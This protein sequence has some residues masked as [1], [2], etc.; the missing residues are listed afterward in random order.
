MTR[1]SKAIPR[2]VSEL[3]ALFFPPPH[4]LGKVKAHF[5]GD[6]LI[7]EVNSAAGEEAKDS[8][9]RRWGP[10]LIDNAERRM[11][12][13]LAAAGL[14]SE[15][16]I[17]T[18]VVFQTAHGEF[19]RGVRGL[20]KLAKHRGH[21]IGTEVWLAA[22]I[23][24]AIAELRDARAKN[25]HDQR[26]HLAWRLG[27]LEMLASVVVDYPELDFGL[28]QYA[29]LGRAREAT[30]KR[31]RAKAASKHQEWVKAARA[32]WARRPSLSAKACADRV[33]GELHLTATI[34]T[35]RQII[36]P[37]HPKVDGV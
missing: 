10:N 36:A 30:S 33:I 18:P 1:K 20:D 14:P 11:Q 24:E 13:I 29:T 6:T 2:T 8:F 25:N 5:D 34:N 4:H 23:V 27:L 35:V 37:Y 3:V 21:D 28:K 12:E 16:G 32:I 19:T 31:R 9:K 26:E 22:K 15:A 7:I 17:V